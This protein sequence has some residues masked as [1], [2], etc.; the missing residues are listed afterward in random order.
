MLVLSEAGVL[1]EVVLIV[2]L[3]VVH[4]RREKTFPLSLTKH[5][6]LCLL[7]LPQ[8]V[9]KFS[10]LIFRLFLPYHNLPF[11]IPFRLLGYRR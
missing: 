7:T 2:S 8:T 5:S 3:L 1:E 6:W 11:T 9:L 10:R 4:K